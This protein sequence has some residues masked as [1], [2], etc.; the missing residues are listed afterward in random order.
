METLDGRYRLQGEIARG[1]IGTV[2]RGADTVTGEPVAVKLLRAEAAV[3]P[4]LVASFAAE[5]EILGS[6]DHPSVVRLREVVVDP[7]GHPA[8][9]ME[10]IAGDDLRRLL[11]RDGPMLPTKVAEV[12]AHVAEALAHLHERGIVHGDVK[13]GNLLLPADGGR[14]R[15]ADFG[16]ARRVTDDLG[17]QAVQ[18]TPEYVAPEVVAGAAPAAAADVYALGIVLFELLSGRSPFRGGSPT[19]VLTRHGTCAPVPPPGLP[20]VIWPVIEDCL[21]VRPAHR[22]DADALAARLRGVEPALDGVPALPRPTPEQVTWWPR[23]AGATTAV[24]RVSWVPLQA[25]PVS[26]ASA[27]AGRMIAIPVADVAGGP[28]GP[29][30]S[31]G[32]RGDTR[33]SRG[34]PTRARETGASGVV[35]AAGPAAEGAASDPPRVGESS[36]RGARSPTPGLVVAGLALAGAVLAGA[37]AVAQASDTDAAPVRGR[38]AIPASPGGGATPTTPGGT[39]TGGTETSSPS[40]GET[41]SSAS[42]DGS[43][44]PG[45]PNPGGLPGI[46]E[47]MPT[48][49]RF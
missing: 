47:P 9:V 26:P 23:P 35:R 4:E 33:A 44:L 6:V 12:V 25:A 5:A 27:Y 38:A 8:I 11:R 22:P 43:A 32:R 28:T 31:A 15:L 16:V 18:A 13:P 39:E 3:Q 14:V 21:A 20:P 36:G 24:A 30:A 10:L 19:Q 37:I 46:G 42:V 34:E 29:A 2:W 49:P 17:D 41:R 48:I 7:R 40:P 45:G 1:A